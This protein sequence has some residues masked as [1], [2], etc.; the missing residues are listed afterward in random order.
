MTDKVTD[1][2]I[3]EETERQRKALEPTALNVTF[4]WKEI[5]ATSPVP[6]GW[7]KVNDRWDPT[8]CGRPTSIVYNVWAIQRYDNQPVGTY[9][10]VCAQA[11]TPSG[12]VL[13][14]THWDPTRC[15]YPHSTIVHNMKQIKRVR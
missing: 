2:E 6:A 5:C 10:T 13:V 12:W 14:D 1:K 3:Q 8:I 11:P 7:I 9:M 15:G 4:E